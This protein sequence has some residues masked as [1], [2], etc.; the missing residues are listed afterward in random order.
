M[1]SD[2]GDGAVD[3]MVD[4]DGGPVHVRVDGPDD[5]PALLFVHG[6]SGSIHWFDDLTALLVPDFRV[7]RVDLR[8]HGRTG[9][10]TG[11]DPESQ[12]RALVSVLDV[13]NAREVFALGHS[14]GA[15]VVLALARRTDRV[16]EVGILGQA[17]DY[18]YA[19]LPPGGEIMALPV[20][21]GLLH[22]LAPTFAVRQGLRTGVAP[23]FPVDNA[24]ADPMTPVRDHRAMSPAM[25]G[26]VLAQRRK[27]LAADPLDAQVR[28]LG[29]PCLVIHGDRDR[30]YDVDRTVARYRAAGATVEIVTGAGHSPNVERPHEVARILRA[31]LAR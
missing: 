9:G 15:D 2:L 20:L 31:H 23:G 4:A 12:S 5:A 1:S 27:R 21:G 7:L 24:F 19:T 25:Y 16:R 17:P 22:R 8:G 18:S 14:F 13:L 28:A 10:H 30:M 29:K 26:I 11:L 3:R 6:F